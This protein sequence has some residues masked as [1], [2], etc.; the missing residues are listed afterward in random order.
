M[1]KHTGLGNNLFEII[2]HYVFCKSNNFE[3]YFPD[4]K[5]LYDKISSYPKNTI[6]RNFKYE[7][8]KFEENITIKKIKNQKWF[9]ENL[10]IYKKD[11]IKLLSID[12]DTKKYLYEKYINKC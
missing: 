5:L 8:S 7:L 6:Y 12:N 10:D 11:I 9:L 2:T 4:I 3:F 1:K